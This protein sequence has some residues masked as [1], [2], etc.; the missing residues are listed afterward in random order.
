MVNWHRRGLGLFGLAAFGLAIPAAAE[1]LPVEGVYGSQ[2]SLPGDVEVIATEGFGGD[3]GPDV[4]IALT[5][6]L[7]D[8][9]LDG[10]QQY[11]SRALEVDP[12]RDYPQAGLDR[13]FRKMRG[14]KQLADRSL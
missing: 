4:A 7:G 12:G 14:A 13:V 11:Y 1:T 5:D 8:V 6:A 2:V 9:I 3:A 10:A